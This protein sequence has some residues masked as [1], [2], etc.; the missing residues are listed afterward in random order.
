MPVLPDEVGRVSTLTQPAP[1]RRTPLPVRRALLVVAALT[2]LFLVATG[3]YNLLDVA[4]RHTTTKQASFASVREL[5]V[6][7]AGD[8]RLTGAPAGAPLRVVTRITEGVREPG[9]SAVR[10]AGGGLRLSSSCPGFFGGQCGVDYEISV[11]AGTAVRVDASE[12]DVAAEDLTTTRPLVLHS[13]AGDVRATDVAAPSIALSSSA[14]D[15]QARELSGERIEAGSSAGDVVASIKTPAERLLAHSSAGNVELLVPN[16][17]YRVDATSSAGD[18]DADSVRTDP[19][20]PR[21]ITAHSSAGDVRI[22]AA[23]ANARRSAP[24]RA[25]SRPSA[26]S[27]GAPGRQSPAGP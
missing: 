25:R 11:P 4:S 7:D 3:A 13:S 21:T 12:G 5:V 17:I 2:A 9:R 19:S 14:G 1:A 8:V 23:D 16:A 10:T 20:A 18:V 6:E 22:A 26:R 27:A 15:V 24:V